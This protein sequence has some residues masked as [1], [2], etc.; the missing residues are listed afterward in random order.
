MQTFSLVCAVIAQ[1][2]GSQ[3]PIVVDSD[4]DGILEDDAGEQDIDWILPN[5]RQA[6]IG[7]IEERE[8]MEVS[9]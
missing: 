5:D 3:Q 8:E 4:S 2:N 9:E 1:L 7:T 6:S